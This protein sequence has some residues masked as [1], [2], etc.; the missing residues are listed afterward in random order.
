MFITKIVR[1][2]SKSINLKSYG[3][4]ESWV[5]IESNIEGAVESQDDPVAVSKALYNQAKQ[6]VIEGA[7]EIIKMIQDSQRKPVATDSTPVTQTPPVQ[8]T[9]SQISS[10]ASTGRVTL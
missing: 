5:K 3:L 4:A 1:T 9:V 10:P 8:G 2:Y 7:S 6:E